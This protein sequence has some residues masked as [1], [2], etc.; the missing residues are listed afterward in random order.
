MNTCK[1][2]T[3]VKCKTSLPVKLAILR[4]SSVQFSHTVVSNS[5]RPHGLQHARLPCPSPTPRACSNSYPSIGDAI[6]PSHP[7]SSPS[8]P[9]FSLSQYQCLFQCIS[10]SHQVA[11][12]WSFSFS[13]SLF[14]EYSGLSSF[15]IDL[16]DL[17]AVQGTL[18]ESSPAPQFESI[19]CISP[20]ATFLLQ[21]QS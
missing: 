9:A 16:S 19:T 4:V 14:N 20:M 15:K 17:F 11:K 6:K 5:L 3:N 2:L 8:P 18:Q 7:L 10:S 12:Y 1:S 21:L 13:I